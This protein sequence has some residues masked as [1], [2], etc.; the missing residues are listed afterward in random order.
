MT[1]CNHPG[2]VGAYTHDQAGGAIP[3]GSRIRKVGT[4]PHDRTLDGTPGTVLGSLD[5]AMIL[6][7][8]AAN[9]GIKFMYFV[10]WDDNPTMAI[11]VIDRKVARDQ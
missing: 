3:N 6:P 9:L 5:A 4:E 1:L 11:A 7:I 10:V 2:M 8:P